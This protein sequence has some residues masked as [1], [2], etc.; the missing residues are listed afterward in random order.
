MDKRRP[1]VCR[2][3]QGLPPDIRTLHKEEI[4]FHKRNQ[5]R[6]REKDEL[7]KKRRKKNA[8]TRVMLLHARRAST[9]P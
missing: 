8:A 6:K 9:G 1:H 2:V 7:K 4:S 5:R 3:E